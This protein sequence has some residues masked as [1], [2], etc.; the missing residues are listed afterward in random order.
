MPAIPQPQRFYAPAQLSGI[1]PTPR[2]QPAQVRAGQG[3]A[4]AFAQM[5]PYRATRGGAPQSAT[6]QAGIRQIRPMPTGE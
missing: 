6:A 5:A 3:Q 2:W 4:A 1:R